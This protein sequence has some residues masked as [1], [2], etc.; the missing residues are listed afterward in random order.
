MNCNDAQALI[1]AYADGETNR[2]RKHSIEAHLRACPECAAKHEQ[3]LT[4]R[5]RLRAEVPRYS[6]PAGLRGR[7]QAR[8]ETTP[9]SRRQT[10]LA[11]GGRWGWAAGGAL[12]GCAA[13]MLAWFVGTTVLEWRVNQDVAVEAVTS[14]VRA[15]L[16]NQLVQ[17]ASSD[18]HT[19]KPWLSA[20]LDYSPPVRDFAS[21]GFPLVGGRVDYLDGRAVATLVY[22]FR[23]HTID[24]FVR[25]ESARAP[26]AMRTLRGFNVAHATGSGMDWLA[27]SDANADVLA[28]FVQRV[29]RESTAE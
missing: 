17:V 8:I 24:V 9:P 13:T 20:H 18:Q 28:S 16:A 5:A 23:N 15:T 4:L 10:S 21:D 22:R 29:A 3:V 12:A 7:V 6:A 1:G 27:V 25:P 2:L 26:P 14:H 11:W 19:V